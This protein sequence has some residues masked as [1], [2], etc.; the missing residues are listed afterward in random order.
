MASRSRRIQNNAGSANSFLD[1]VAEPKAADSKIAKAVALAGKNE[2]LVNAVLSAVKQC[3]DDSDKYQKKLD[4][5]SIDVTLGRIASLLD[6]FKSSFTDNE[7]TDAKDEILKAIS[8][9]STSSFLKTFLA[10]QISS[11]FDDSATKDD[12]E[13]LKQWILENVGGNASNTSEEHPTFENDEAL[14]ED[15]KEGDYQDST[16]AKNFS[17]LN[18]AIDKQFNALNKRMLVIPGIF[19][20]VTG[21][22]S[23]VGKGFGMVFTGVAKLTKGV[24]NVASKTISITKYLGKAALSGIGAAIAGIG[25]GIGSVIKGVGS[26]AKN[27]AQGIGGLGKKIG[28]A[29][30][31]PFKAVGGF[32]SKL[33]PFKRA[34]DKRD[35]RRQKAKDKMME[36]MSKVIDKIWKCVEPIVDKI[37]FVISLISKFVIIP[38]LFITAQILL[39][40]GAVVALTVGIV[41]AAMWIKNKIVKFWNYITSGEI[42]KDMADALV[43]AWEWIKDLG[44]WI[45]EKLCQFGNWLYENYIYKYIVKPFKDYVL[46]PIRKLWNNKVWPMIEPFITSLTEL[47]NK[48]VNAFSAWDTN[49]SVWENLKNIGGIIRDSIADWWNDDN[50]PVRKMYNTYISPF[51]ESITNLKD[52]IVSAFSGWDTS[53]S[54]WENMKN[55]GGII[56]DS[57]ADWWNDD[58]NPIKRVYNEY[59]K[60]MIDTVKE[61]IQPLVDKFKEILN[62]LGNMTWDLGKWIGIIRPFGFLIGKTFRLSEAEAEEYRGV[63]A[64]N[65]QADELNDD[66]EELKRIR[67]EGKTELGYLSNPILRAKYGSGNLDDIIAEQE[68]QRDSI[69]SQASAELDRIN[70]RN[71][72]QQQVQQAAKPIQSIEQMRSSANVELQKTGEEISTDIAQKEEQ[73]QKFD[74]SQSDKSDA[75]LTELKEFRQEANKKLDDPAAIPVP[76][77]INTQHNSATMRS[78]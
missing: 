32:V 17:T 40:V 35:E 47:K 25:K 29:I 10:S 44:K 8:G 49:K 75:L 74:Q 43:K 65:K 77:P 63:T 38:I 59:I 55:I 19:G 21:L 39:V 9:I 7:L 4:S 64:K 66:I 52:K 48:I 2:K 33:N 54:V 34:E 71:L 37:G 41:L 30:A 27:V 11:L 60:P 12:I 28:G 53:K 58:K 70:A 1:A 24:A 61:K 36:V 16:P 72:A 57:I 78:N 6:E 42:W 15:N 3:I 50:N 14:E 20:I 45:W 31:S 23:I 18:T 67:A 5:K 26:L 76:V 56:R 69:R 22:T 46:D 73:K 13:D 68:K 62:K 51:V